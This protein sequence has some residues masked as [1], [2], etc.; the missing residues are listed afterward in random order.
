[1]SRGR[2]P[3]LRDDFFLLPKK[4][5]KKHRTVLHIYSL[6]KHRTETF[7]SCPDVELEGFFF[8]LPLR[9]IFLIFFSSC[10]FS[11]TFYRRPIWGSSSHL[12]PPAPKHHPHS[13]W[14]LNGEGNARVPALTLTLTRA[15]ASRPRSPR[16]AT[17]S[18]THGWGR[19]AGRGWGGVLLTFEGSRFRLLAA[20]H[21]KS[22]QLK[23]FQFS[24]VRNYTSSWPRAPR[25][26]A[27]R[28]LRSASLAPWLRAPLLAPAPARARAR[29]SRLP[30]LRAL[31]SGGS[32]CTKLSQPSTPTP[33]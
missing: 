12:N 13:T 29:G 19:K 32:G 28:A 15:H 8:F 33:A 10:L 5:K 26:A 27:P 18:D 23:L 17:H 16:S 9:M 22:K 25:A 2:F 4:G 6:R 1:M 20:R 21:P 31:H 30:G 7:S 3:P 11:P 14:G 24:P